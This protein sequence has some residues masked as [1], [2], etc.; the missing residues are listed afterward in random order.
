MRPLFNPLP[1]NGP[2]VIFPFYHAVSDQPAPHYKHLF[3][4]RNE[5]DFRADLDFF[6][7]HFK[8]LSLEEAVGYRGNKPGFHLSFDDG[9]SECAETIAPIL[10]EQGVPA[11]FFINPAFLNN[12]SMMHRCLASLLIEQSPAEKQ[13]WLSF[14]YPEKDRLFEKAAKLGL[15][16]AD[17]LQKQQPYL[18]DNQLKTLINDG[19]SIGAHSIDHPEFPLISRNEQVVQVEDSLKVVHSLSEDTV[20]AFAFPFEDL[21][22]DAACFEKVTQ[23]GAYSFGT[24]GIK[25]DSRPNHFQRM[26]M[27]KALYSGGELVE[28]AYLLQKFR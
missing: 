25:A 9:F 5:K 21:G 15:D 20:Q 6:L 23:L 11:T 26:D 8:P 10:K 28:A 14:R 17:Y 16:I 3:H 7:R 4:T 2:E 13:K 24:S 27:E 22:A 19:F 12:R 1:R 18:T